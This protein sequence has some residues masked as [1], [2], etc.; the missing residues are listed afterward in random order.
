[1][2]ATTIAIAQASAAGGQGGPSN[3]HGFMTHHPSTFARGGDPVVVNHWFWQVGRILEAMEITSDAMRIR[4]ATF[5]LEGK[6][7]V[8]WDWIKVSRDLETMTWG[9]F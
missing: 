3:L 4:L 1:M 2:G 8:W 6:S 7:Q 9:E 5:K